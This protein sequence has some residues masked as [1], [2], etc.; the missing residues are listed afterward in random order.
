MFPFF[1]SK[2]KQYLDLITINN[3]PCIKPC[4]NYASFMEIDSSYI[5]LI[6]STYRNFLLLNHAVNIF[7]FLSLNKYTS[8]YKASH[9]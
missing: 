4:L 3:R 6:K 5:E 1:F 7:F 2:D 8:I 9:T